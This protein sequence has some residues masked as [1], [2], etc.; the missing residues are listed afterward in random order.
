MNIDYRERLIFA[1]DLP[2]IK[3]AR[4]IVQLLGDQVR[5]L[6]LGMELSMNAGYW[7]FVEC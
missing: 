7:D 2:T 6:K 1:L 4:N 3:E 5:V